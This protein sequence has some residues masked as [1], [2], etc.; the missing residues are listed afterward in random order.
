MKLSKSE[1]TILMVFLI[2]IV[3]AGGGFLFVY[4]AYQQI[5]TA[6]A[7][8]Q[9]AKDTLE[10]TKLTLQREDTI[11]DEVKDAYNAAKDY[12]NKFYKDL[13]TQEADV[14]VRQIL[15]D[16]KMT[17][18][19]LSISDLTASTLSL[20]DFVDVEVTYPLKEYSKSLSAVATEEEI[21]YDE[22]GNP[23][24]TAEQKYAELS[25]YQQVVGAVNVTFTV[26]GRL[27]DLRAFLDAINDL[28]QA[29]YI[30]S[31]TVPYTGTDTSTGSTVELDEE[32]NETIVENT[33][34]TTT[35]LKASS[36][37]STAV[38]LVLYCVNPMD[39]PELD[40]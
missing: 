35:D 19:A 31:I 8:L 7:S 4:P 18:N 27:D 25:Q 5:G 1:R 6:Q 11:D 21:Q 40:N 30:Q 26:D 17:T 34:E 38:S 28:P 23:I 37:V 20:T 9:S 32:G 33:T 3:I 13:E 29:T 22:D 16:T 12:E 14:I 10:T 39:V 2:L 15:E 36:K 24:L